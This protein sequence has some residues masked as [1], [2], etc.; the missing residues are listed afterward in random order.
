M[1]NQK[2]TIEEIE[3]KE[4][5]IA[6]RGYNQHEVDEFLDSICDELERQEAEINALKAENDRLQHQAVPQPF[7]APVA[8]APVA[9]APVEQMNDAT[10]G[11]F[12]E[13]LEMAKRVKDMTIADAKAKAAEIVANA[14]NEA[15]ARLGNMDEEKKQL[16]AELESVKTAVREYKEK[17]AEAIAMAQDALDLTTDL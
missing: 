7:A 1:Q 6:S 8:P 2:I 16:E 3:N 15:K 5:H 9:A 14:E 17:F 4:F 11:T 13:I 10:E 12:R